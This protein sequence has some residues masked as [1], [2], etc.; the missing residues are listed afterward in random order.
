MSEEDVSAYISQGRLPLLK[1]VGVPVACT[2]TIYLSLLRK[3]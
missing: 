2:L 3:C 1:T